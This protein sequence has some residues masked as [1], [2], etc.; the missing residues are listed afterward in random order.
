MNIS[1]LEAL[2][3]AIDLGSFSRAA[4][5]LGYT[6]SGMTHMMNSLETELGFEIISRGYYGIKVT[7][8]GEKILPKIRRLVALDE[9]IRE[10][11]RN[12][13]EKGEAT[14]KVGAYSS[15]ALQWLPAIVQLFN[16][17]HPNISVQISTGSVSEMYDGI[18]S[19]RFDLA[20]VSYNDRFPCEFIHLKDDR[21]MAILPIDYPVD[22]AAPFPLSSYEGKNFLMP[23]LGFDIDIMSIFNKGNVRPH[24]VSTFVDDPAIISMVE[25]GLG[26]S[27]LS[28]LIVRGRSGNVLCLPIEPYVCRDMGIAYAPK[29]KLT[30]AMRQF[31]SYSKKFADNFNMRG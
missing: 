7:E 20:F 16:N 3:T 29:K 30:D 14:I 21:M 4:E 22:I 25:H 23:S 31:I 18:N 11:I 12:I 1:K 13:N 6:Q 24:I 26:I 9:E 10:D 15:V 2:L 8:N 5:K 19:D 28:E 17:D 27:M